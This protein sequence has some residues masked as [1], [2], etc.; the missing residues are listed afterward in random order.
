MDRNRKISSII[1]ACLFMEKR[2]EN[3]YRSFGK[4]ARDRGKKTFWNR[5]ADEEREHMDFWKDLKSMD[6]KGIIKDIFAD[7]DIILGELK[8]IR[9][10]T[11][12]MVKKN[13]L[14]DREKFL[15]AYKLEYYMMHVAFFTLFHFIKALP[16][17]KTP[18]DSYEEHLDYFI[19]HFYQ[20]NEI[21]PGA[22]ILTMT[23]KKLWRDSVSLSAENMTDAL[24]GLNNRRGFMA[25]VIPL[26]YLAQRNKIPVS[27]IMMDI[28]N[29]KEINDTYGHV[30]GDSVINSIGNAIIK[31]IR[32]S[33]IAGRIGGDE[34]IIFMYDADNNN[35]EKTAE[36]IRSANYNKHK[37]CRVT[38]SLGVYSSTVKGDIESHIKNMIKNADRNMYKSKRAGK[39]R[40]TV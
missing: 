33:D 27:M 16:A 25:K 35:A 14:T 2:A 30:L 4:K 10:I 32:Q 6:N 34:F 18:Q 11:D 9:K 31:R 20:Y 38:I 37:Q 26:A 1:N 3:L 13:R 39:N 21:M 19:D 28:D 15:T 5:M 29:F 17:K 22:D 7:P 36:D 40:I 24:S 12:T 23:L 8:D